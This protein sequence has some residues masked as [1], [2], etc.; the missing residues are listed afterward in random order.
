MDGMEVSGRVRVAVDMDTLRDWFAGHALAG[1]LA[2][3]ADPE[4]DEL[5]PGG[6]VARRCYDLADA[7]LAERDA[8]AQAR[9]RAVLE[10]EAAEAA[11]FEG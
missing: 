10:A 2:M 1:Y 11:R 4:I 3:H 6:R 9:R 7:M 5:P 8:R